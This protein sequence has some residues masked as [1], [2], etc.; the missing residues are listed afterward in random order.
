MKLQAIAVLS[1]LLA[2]SPAQAQVYKCTEGGKTVFSDRPCSADD[3]PLQVRPAAG[4]FDP[5]AGKAAEAR[6][7]RDQA[8]LQRIE[9]QRQAARAS[10]ASAIEARQK[11]EQDNCTRIRRDMEQAQ[12]WA[13]EFRHPDNVR[14][15]TEKANKLKDQLW[16]ECKQTR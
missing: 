4:Q 8:E 5:A 10:E 9:L 6:A 2:L 3:A 16:W 13:G 1:A 7:A 12:Y 11:A 14:R 15:E